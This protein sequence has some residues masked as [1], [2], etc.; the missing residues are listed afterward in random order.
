MRITL[1]GSAKFEK[2][3][4]EMNERL[5]LAGHTVYSLAVYPSDKGEKNWYTPEQK[6]VLDAVHLLKIDNSDA[7][8]V[9]TVNGYIGDSTKREIEYA[10]SKGKPVLCSYPFAEGFQR[11]CYY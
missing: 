6:A 10:I 11:T 1:C 8:Y 2:E 4:K 9:I 5:S 3:F 7:I